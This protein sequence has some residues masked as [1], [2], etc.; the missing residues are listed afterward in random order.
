MIY[1]PIN[2]SDLPE[3]STMFVEAFNAPPWNDRWTSETATKRLRQMMNCEGFIGLAC[4]KDK[5]L[6]GMILG[7]IEHYFDCTHFHIKE[8]CVRLNLRG[9]GIGTQLLNE[10]EA[11]LNARGVSKVYLFT[12]RTD[13]T[14]KIYQRRGYRSWNDMVIMGKSLHITE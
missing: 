5:I 12:S 4:Y 1:E 9:S 3:L 6:S 14:E 10:F 7:N 8:F 13:E 2:E 11:R